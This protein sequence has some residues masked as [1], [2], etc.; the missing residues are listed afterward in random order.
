[1]IGKPPNS[2]KNRWYRTLIKKAETT[3]VKK[4]S[5]DTVCRTARLVSP[6]NI[7]VHKEIPITIDEKSTNKFED[8]FESNFDLDEFNFDVHENY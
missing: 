1:M 4:I 8:L 6:S 5:S 2:I 3:F 7:E